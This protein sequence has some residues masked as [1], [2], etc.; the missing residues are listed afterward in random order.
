MSVD[1]PRLNLHREPFVTRHALDRY[2][3]HVPDATWES[4]LLDRR[5]GVEIS[6][7]VAY[8]IVGPP[9]VVEKRDLRFCYMLSWDRA[10]I[11]IDGPPERGEGKRRVLVTYRRLGQAQELLAVGLYPITV[12]PP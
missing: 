10:G 7:E 9:W 3:E 5:R 1:A 6:V 8:C 2:R 4:L 12:G 11:F